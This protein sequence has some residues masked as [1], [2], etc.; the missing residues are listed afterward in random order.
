MNVLF[1]KNSL[2]AQVPFALALSLGA[3]SAMAADSAAVKAATQRFEQ[4]RAICASGRSNQD[5]AT[6]MQEATAALAEVKR[7][8]MMNAND[9]F[10]RNARLRCQALQDADRADCEAR[11]SGQ[12]T[13][14][15]T[16]AGGGIYRE[17]VTREILP[18]EAPKPAETPAR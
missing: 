16:A 13:T 3:A 5:R 2:L 8:R 12:G 7:G 17:L 4:D 9:T 14:T 18:A 6:C 11:M 10:V 1:R 15:G